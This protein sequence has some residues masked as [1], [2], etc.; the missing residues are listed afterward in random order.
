MDEHAP[1][2]IIGQE[3]LDTT[4]RMQKALKEKELAQS[5]VNNRIQVIKRV[6]SQSYR[7]CD[8]INLTLDGKLR[9]PSPKNER[10][11]YISEL[12]LADLLDAVPERYQVERKVILLAMP[13][14]DEAR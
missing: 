7:E 1:G 5:T 2:I 3:Q 11:I 6:L 4:R 9:K 12:E 10:Y 8:W 13:N 14:R